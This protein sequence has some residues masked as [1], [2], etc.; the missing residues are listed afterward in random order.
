MGRTYA[1]IEAGGT[2]FIC[3]VMDEDARVLDQQRIPTTDPKET[4]GQAMAFLAKV[5]GDHGALS[6]LGIASFGPLELNPASPMFGSIISTPKPGWSG[7]DILGSLTEAAGAPTSINTDVNAAALAEIKLGAGQGLSSLCYVTVGTGIGVGYISDG[8]FVPDTAHGEIGHMRVPRAEG[9]TFPG[10]CPFHTDCLEGLASGP[11]IR[12]RWDCSAEDL[13]DDHPAWQM[14][15]HYIAALCNNL[16]YT[17]RPQRIV[18]GGGVFGRASLYGKVRAA[19]GL[20][21]AGYA[22]SSEEE[23]LDSFI[24]PPGLDEIPPG[25]MGAFELAQ[26]AER[27]AP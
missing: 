7:I 23:A 5:R 25:L 16:I 13:P 9:D 20:M 10:R 3:A 8:R 27:G 11:A 4:L 14:E 24:S 26:Q 1:A 18:I 12:D 6:G 15:A 22:L 17:L 2:K 19:L 21:L